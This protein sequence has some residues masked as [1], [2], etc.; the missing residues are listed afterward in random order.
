MNLTLIR[1][2]FTS[3]F[4]LGTL[5]E[6]GVFLGYTCEDTDRHM[7][8]G[9]KKIHGRTA[10]PRGRYQCVLSKSARFKR[11]MPEV[12][13]V[14]G[15]S[16]VRIHGGN[17]HEDTEGCPL[18]GL[19]RTANGVRSCAAPNAELIRLME[20]SAKRGEEVWLSVE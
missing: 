2:K 3:D 15:F 13:N 10:I 19:E 9:G 16:G 14:P 5:S 11:V 6:S 8:V 4:T 18:L 12:L 7:E 1:D 17:T 20:S